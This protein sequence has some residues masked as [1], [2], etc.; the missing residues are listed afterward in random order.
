VILL[1]RRTRSIQ[2]LSSSRGEHS[3]KLA[4]ALPQD[5]ERC[6]DRC[7][8][9]D[10]VRDVSTLH[11]FGSLLE[12]LAADGI[13]RKEGECLRE[14]Y[15]I[16]S[17]MQKLNVCINFPKDCTQSNVADRSLRNRSSNKQSRSAC[18]REALN[19]TNELLVI[20]REDRF[21]LVGDT[22]S[23]WSV[24]AGTVYL[25]RH[26]RQDYKQARK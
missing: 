17:G 20:D 26:Y 9:L 11:F 22:D 19:D 21:L 24:L 13:H 7:L 4:N 25:L 6:F 5:F 12:A 1:Q 16:R 23:R 3:C 2:S 8:F 15:T 18:Q 10:N 14:W